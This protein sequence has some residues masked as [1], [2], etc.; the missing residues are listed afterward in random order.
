MND[1]ELIH[2]Y[3]DGSCLDNQNVTNL[4]SAGWGFCVI[5]GDSGVGSG[6]GELVY[7]L[8]GKVIT[9]PLQTDYIGAEV[10]SNNTGELSAIAH[11]LRW[12]LSKVEECEIVICSDSTYAG[13]I[14]SGKWKAK[15]NKKLATVTQ[16]L[17]REVE[18]SYK[19]SWKHVRA[20]RGHR[21]NERADHLAFRAMKDESVL[22]LQFW[23]PGLR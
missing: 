15:A 18:F 11:S 17:W 14:A 21:W 22:P 4:T 6:K 1:F 8:N 19:L 2:I 5:E 9:D 13:N 23:K 3:V 20:H 10:G 16:N 7:E 12:V